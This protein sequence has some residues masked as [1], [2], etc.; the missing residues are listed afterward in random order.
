MA[1]LRRIA[2]FIAT[3]IDWVLINVFAGN[4]SIE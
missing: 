4:E 2:V 1:W 3:A